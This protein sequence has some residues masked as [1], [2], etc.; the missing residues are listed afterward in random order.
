[1]EPAGW[2]GGDSER[3]GGSR[4][5]AAPQCLMLANVIEDSKQVGIEA[6]KHHHRASIS[7]RGR[8]KGSRQAGDGRWQR[9]LT[10]NGLVSDSELALEMGLRCLG[11]VTTLC[12]LG[13]SS[14]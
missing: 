1:M 5:E 12:G 9:E 6:W 11:G 14:L 8:S 7:G 10:E 13:D 3:D 4:H 2:R